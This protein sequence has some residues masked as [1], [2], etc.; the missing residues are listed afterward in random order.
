LPY[1]Q[2]IDPEPCSRRVH[3]APGRVRGG[4]AV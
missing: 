2:G 4:L 1:R 3:D